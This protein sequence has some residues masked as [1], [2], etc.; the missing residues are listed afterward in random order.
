MSMW[1]KDLHLNPDM[2]NLIE[3]KMGKCLEQICTG[4]IFLKGTPMAQALD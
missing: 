4:E 2:L 1:I 3:D